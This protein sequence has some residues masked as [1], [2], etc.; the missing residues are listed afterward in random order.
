MNGSKG[1]NIKEKFS[2]DVNKITNWI[3]NNKL[4]VILFVSILGIGF[5]LIYINSAGGDYGSFLSVWCKYLRDNGGFKAIVS[6]ETDY[7]AIYLYFL[8]LFSYIP[9]K[10]LYLIKILSFIFDFIMAFSGAAIIGHL[11]RDSKN[12]NLYEVAVFT[13]ILLMPTVVW[14]SARWVQCDSIYTALLFLSIYFMLKKKYDLSFIFFGVAIT[15]KLQAIFL[16][17]A[18]GI[19]FLKNKEFSMFKFLWVPIVN[20]V[21]YI[22]AIIIGKPVSSIL[23]AYLCQV[24]KYAYKTVLGY[25]NIY[26]FFPI[27]KVGLIKPGIALTMIL[28]FSLMF[29]VL[30]TKDKLTDEEIVTLSVTVVFLVTFFLPEMHDRYGYV[31]EVLAMVYFF[32]VK[33]DWIILL[34]VNSN[35][36]ITY[37]SF[38]DSI[39]ES[40]MPKVAIFQL[41]VVVYFV[42]KFINI[43]M[44]SCNIK[45][46]V[47]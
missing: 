27:D 45:N 12:K 6:V 16:L 34:L 10:D 25:P 2:C 40:V 44:N 29:F 1:T 39:P 32:M 5:R 21:L 36:L 31:A 19:I 35:A 22:P 24:G 11:K 47:S 7:N 38:L 46:A 13:G 41:I 42:Y 17:P 9:I 43:E 28:L 33:K 23:D 8:A 14:N 3:N 30:F 4:F 20:F 18:Y 37:K 26:Y 15:F